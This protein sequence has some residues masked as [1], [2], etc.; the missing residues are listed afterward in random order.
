MAGMEAKSG[1]DALLAQVR[2]HTAL[3]SADLEEVQRVGRALAL[4]LQAVGRQQELMSNLYVQLQRLH[5]SL[6]LSDVVTALGETLTNLVGTEDFAVLL[7]DHDSGRY[8][9]LVAVGGGESVASFAPGEGV[10]GEAAL[11]GELRLGEPLAAVPLASG[12]RTGSIGMIVI[13]HLLRHKTELTARD[14]PLLEAFAGHAG[15]A[16][17]AAMYAEMAGPVSF[18]VHQLRALLH[19]DPS[20]P[21][22]A[23]EKSALRDDA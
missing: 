10:L 19:G 13:T 8:E 5:S 21:P 11:R 14:R 9:P 3:M 12:V 22:L 15:V 16:L 7:L 6:R 2:Q 1:L 23:P 20:L 4:E 17:E 18:R